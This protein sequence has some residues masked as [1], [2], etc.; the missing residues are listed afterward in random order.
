MVSYLPLSSFRK[1]TGR[2][3]KSVDYTFT[4]YQG[5][6]TFESKEPAC[7]V[8]WTKWFPF[9]PISRLPKLLQENRNALIPERI[10]EAVIFLNS[11]HDTFAPVIPA[12]WIDDMIYW[13][14]LQHPS[15]EFLLQSNWLDRALQFEHKLSWLKDRIYIATTF[16]TD[17]Q[18]ILTK[19]GFMTPCLET[20][21]A[22]ISTFKA[23]GYRTRISLEPLYRFNWRRLTDMVEEAGPELVEMGLDNYMN[24]HKLEI[25]QPSRESCII[26]KENLEALGIEV[27]L[28]TS[29]KKFLEA[30]HG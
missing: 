6:G 2:M 20:R 22:S 7:P 25:P 9:G 28:K 4:Y 18:S 17:D 23:L 26:I 11:A 1:T 21:L 15:I 10:Q 12:Q 5:C 8:C 24:R 27:F 19:F 16:Q 13:M 30:R 3:F 29:M 14:G